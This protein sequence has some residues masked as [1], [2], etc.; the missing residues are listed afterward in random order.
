MRTLTFDVETMPLEGRVFGLWQQNIGLSQIQATDWMAC[1]AAKFHGERKVHF[2]SVWDD[3]ARGMAL[4]LHRLFDEADVVIGWNSNRFDIPWANRV[5]MESNK[6]RPS[7]F[8][9]VD[10]MRS[11]KQQ[12]RLPSYKLDFVSRWLG[13]EGK[14]RTGGFDLWADVMAGHPAAR[15]KMRRYNIQD[16]KL[17]EQVFDRLREKGWVKGLPNH[18]IHDGH[19]CPNCGSEKL[20]ARGYAA[21]LTRRYRQWQCQ[22][23]KS[24]SRSVL[25]EPGSAS[26]KA[27]P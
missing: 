16:T 23:C 17:T 14:L 26:L 12:F 10:L 9:K 7:P 8:A 13:L 22:S 24:W 25:C 18:S 5:F 3:G 21:T 1:F 11:V 27:A 19:V 6:G 2:H 20:Q 15:R 4:A